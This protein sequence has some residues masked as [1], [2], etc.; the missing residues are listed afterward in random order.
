[1]EI[2]LES[3]SHSIGNSMCTVC[4]VYATKRKGILNPIIGVDLKIIFML[5]ELH[6]SQKAFAYSLIEKAELSPIMFV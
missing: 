4:R 5:Q 2:S 1:M 6:F 3:T